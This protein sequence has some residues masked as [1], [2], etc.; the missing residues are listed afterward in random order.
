MKNPFALAGVVTYK[1]NDLSIVGDNS[2]NGDEK[3]TNKKA[4]EIIRWPDQLS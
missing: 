4:T 2:N 3:A 1:H